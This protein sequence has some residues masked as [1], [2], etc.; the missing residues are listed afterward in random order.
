MS[1]YRPFMNFDQHIRK[2]ND[3]LQGTELKVI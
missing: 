1:M 2:L 3:A